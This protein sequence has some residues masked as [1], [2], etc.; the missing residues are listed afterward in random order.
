[1]YDVVGKRIWQ[2]KHNNTRSVS[3]DLSELIVGMYFLKIKT[4]N[5]TITHKLIK[6]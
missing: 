5:G 6:K 1:V 4:T 3:I 2:K